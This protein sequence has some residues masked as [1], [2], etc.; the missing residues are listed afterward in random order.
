MKIWFLLKEICF[1]WLRV[2][3][4][5]WVYLSCN[6]HSQSLCF[7]NPE[8]LGIKWDDCP[9]RR[10]Y[11]NMGNWLKSYKESFRVQKYLDDEAGQNEAGTKEGNIWKII[12]H[13]PPWWGGWCGERL[14]AP[15]KI[16]SEEKVLSRACLVLRR[17]E[18]DS[19]LFCE[20]TS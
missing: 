20:E 10:F 5:L 11:R 7:K 19:M 3:L 12:H 1:L 8:I 15:S 4:T 18:C 17:I 14:I 6:H 16:P 13:Q 9:A 2:Y